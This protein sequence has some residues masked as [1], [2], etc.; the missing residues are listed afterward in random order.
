MTAYFRSGGVLLTFGSAELPLQFE[1][2]SAKVCIT[3][4]ESRPGEANYFLGGD[5]REWKT[6]L[7]LYQSISYQSAWTGV[8]VRYSDTGHKLK[9]DFFVGPGADVSRI[10]VRYGSGAVVSIAP[11]GALRVKT[12]T[13]ELLED[14]PVV[15][16]I[17]LDHQRTPVSGAY[18]LYPDGSVGFTVGAYDHAR[19]LV[20]DPIINYSSYLGGNGA[21]SITGVA[22]D[23]NGNSL[24]AGFTA[25]SNLPVTNAAQSLTGGSVDA[26]VAKFSANGNRLI[27]CTYFG[28]S[29]DDRAFALA[30][31]RSGNA[32]ITGWTGSRNLPLL[33]AFQSRMGSARDAFV[34][35]LNPAGNV[36]LFSTYYGGGGNDVG[37]GIAVD[38]GGNVYIVGDTASINLPLMTPFQPAP[39]GGVDAFVAKFNSTGSALSFSTY[40]GG[41]YDEHGAAI[42]VDP[43]GSV[44]ITGSTSSSDFPVVNAYQAHTGG[45]QDAFVTKIAASGTA[46][47]FSTY[48]GGSGGTPGLPETGSGIAVDQSGFVYVAGTTSSL[49][50]PTT[51]GAFQNASQ[52]GNV[53]AFATKYN[54][55]GTAL[56]YSTYIGGS[57]IDQ[58]TGI[59]I[60]FV[61]NAY[62][63]GY[64]GSVDFP[65][66]RA[67]QTTNHGGYDAFLTKLNTGGTGLAYSTYLGGAGDDAANGVAVDR[68]G[69]AFVAGQTTSIDFPI[70]GAAQTTNP[71][72]Y[73][74]FVTRIVIGWLSTVV[75]GNTWCMDVL[76][77]GGSDGSS[78]TA[79]SI[80]FGQPG[81]INISGDWTGTGQVRMGVFRA[82]LWLLDINGNGVW[83][84]PSGGDRQI[85]FGSAG[86]TPVL[87]DWNGTGTLKAGTFR[88]GHWIL[89]LS[90]HLSGVPTG[91][92]DLNFW[93]GGG[94]NVP[95]VG[96]WTG[97]G[98]TKVGVYNLGNWALDWNGDGVYNNLDKVYNNYGNSTDIP[99]VGDWDGSGV[100]KI[101]LYRNGLWIL[102]YVGNGIM[103]STYNDMT[104]WFG[105][106]GASPMI[107]N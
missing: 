102:N 16:Q 92:R 3:P 20:I 39:G 100:S 57:S 26:F 73:G 24:V 66:I 81:D 34:A 78:Y 41:S 76:R 96:D 70:I 52:G 85:S 6:S 61:G 37:Y 28:G 31:D 54:P 23:A 67:V 104:F 38:P 58:A 13:V 93:F 105:P 32:Y 25:S 12:D 51:P 69:T 84:G 42:A 56:M 21:D 49:N 82:G 44:Y 94:T 77:D 36:L 10:H 53:D 88:Q 47:V 7:P 98:T 59:A 30:V 19:Q 75:A 33:N 55:S 17:S 101:G 45:N 107:M 27:Y 2:S 46:L 63:T 1:N 22:V 72:Y 103:N 4:G 11:D 65:N 95:V 99:I 29:G 91:L 68:F 106:A 89:D 35:K 18:R 74:G 79:K 62:V 15:Y 5:S 50:F 9:T 86:D 83:D 71:D 43:G 80:S 64:T 40:V 60:D 8:D 14:A 48:L 87:G 90:G 97:N